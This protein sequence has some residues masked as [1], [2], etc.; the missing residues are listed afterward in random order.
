VNK[1]WNP[2]SLNF[3]P[4]CFHKHLIFNRANSEL[5]LKIQTDS[6]SVITKKVVVQSR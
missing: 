4:L 3:S 1:V 2:K 5:T 6:G